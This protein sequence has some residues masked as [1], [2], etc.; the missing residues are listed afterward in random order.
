MLVRITNVK[1]SVALT[2]IFQWYILPD[3][4]SANFH[5]ATSYPVNENA[6]NTRTDV[7]LNDCLTFI[8]LYNFTAKNAGAFLTI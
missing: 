8:L 5:Y 2:L 3:T 6:R 4:H 1:F 7:T